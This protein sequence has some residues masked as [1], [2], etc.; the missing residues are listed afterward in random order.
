MILLAHQLQSMFLRLLPL[1]L[2]PLLELNQPVLNQALLFLVMLSAVAMLYQTISSF[3]PSGSSTTAIVAPSLTPTIS[4]AWS[5]SIFADRSGGGTVNSGTNITPN[6]TGSVS[7]TVVNNSNCTIGR[8][9]LS[10]GAAT[11]TRNTTSATAAINNAVSITIAPAGTPQ[12]P[13][14]VTA[15]DSATFNDTS[16]AFPLGMTPVS[17]SAT[18]NDSSGAF[19]LGM[20]PTA[21]S[22]SFNDSSGAFPLGMSPTTDSSTFTESATVANLGTTLSLNDSGSLT[23]TSSNSVTTSR[24]DSASLSESSSL[25]VTHSRTDSASGSDSSG[26]TN[27]ASTTDSALVTDVSQPINTSTQIVGSENLAL[28]ESSSVSA[29]LSS[30]DSGLLNDGDTGSTTWSRTDSAS[31]F[32]TA[33]INQAR[34]DSATLSDSSKV[35]E[36]SSEVFAFGDS[37]SLSIIASDSAS[38]LDA[39]QPLTQSLADQATFTESAQVQVWTSS[40]ESLTLNDGMGGVTKPIK[41]P[42]GDSATLSESASAQVLP[43]YTEDTIIYKEPRLN[44]SFRVIAQ[45]HFTREFIHW[46]LPLDNIKVTYS[47]TGPNILVGQISSEME[48]IMTLDPPLTPNRTWLHLEEDGVIRG[49][50]LLTPFVDAPANQVRQ[51]EAEGFSMY[52]HWVYYEDNPFTGIQ[53]DP[54][55]MVRRLWNHVQS[56]TDGNLGVQVASTKTPIKL[57]EPPEQVAFTTTENVSVSFQAGP[58]TLNY[59]SVTNCGDEIDKLCKETP[60]DYLEFSYWNAEKND[61]VHKLLLGYPRL[62]TKRTDLVFRE[63]ENLAQLIPSYQGSNDNYAS[64]VVVIGAGNGPSAVRAISSKRIGLLR[65]VNVIQNQDITNHTRAQSIADFELKRIS[66]SRFLIENITV[67]LSHPN[68]PWGSFA[69]GDDILVDCTVL[70][71]GHVQAWYRIISYIY[72]PYQKTAVISLAPSDSFTYGAENV[73][74]YDE[75]PTAG[76]ATLGSQQ[77]FSNLFNSSSATNQLSQL[78]AYVTQLVQQIGCNYFNKYGLPNGMCVYWYWIVDHPQGGNQLPQPGANV[79]SLDILANPNNKMIIGKTFYGHILTGDNII[80]MAKE[81]TVG[82]QQNSQSDVAYP[83]P[84]YVP[85]GG[86]ASQAITVAHPDDNQYVKD[87]VQKAVDLY[88][89]KGL[90]ND[91]AYFYDVHGEDNYE[92]LEGTY[93]QMNSA[94]T[95]II[96]RTADGTLQINGVWLAAN[97]NSSA[98]TQQ[99][100]GL[101]QAASFILSRIQSGQPIYEDWSWDG[102]PFIVSQYNDTLLSKYSGYHNMPVVQFLSAVI[103]GQIT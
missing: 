77:D 27:T 84:Y 88:N 18:F 19:P 89:Q 68:A 11:G 78:Q 81:G 60:M 58:Y 37:S 57:G 93:E 95:F 45:D 64:D 14:V 8:W 82:Q 90:E 48:S 85:Q 41:S 63:G 76:F 36:S 1:V 51:I 71:V 3:N 59:W 87:V 83:N 46:E 39:S 2:K 67:D 32:E 12:G 62:G 103:N 34:T 66:H 98:Q 94:D 72:D 28:T 102:E 25:L 79:G 15:N 13:T 6:P 42:D 61:V 44:R 69:P 35:S 16:G 4:T 43:R 17:D 20:T 100:N 21:D 101:Q 26:S 9:T 52:P 22:A 24:T 86:T 99:P 96:G 30:T 56:Y 7:P 29:T 74:P 55:D 47:L 40:S 38:L 10:S 33:Q 80:L 5:F 50:F 54:A 23:D 92:L 97:G 75:L 65:K 73:D 91:H 70:Y 49:S 53:V 31:L